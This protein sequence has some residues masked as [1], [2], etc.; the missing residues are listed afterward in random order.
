MPTQ[1]IGSVSVS[2]SK[3]KDHHW[4]AVASG[5]PHGC[6]DLGACLSIQ[7]SLDFV[8]CLS[9]L[10]LTSL[11]VRILREKPHQKPCFNCSV[12]LH[13]ASQLIT[14]FSNSLPLVNPHWLSP[15]NPILLLHAQESSFQEYLF[16]TLPR[17]QMRMTRPISPHPPSHPFED[18]CDI[19]P[20]P[21]TRSFPQSPQPFKDNKGPTCNHVGQSLQ[22]TRK[23]FCLHRKAGNRSTSLKLN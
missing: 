3:P 18:E 12:L 14:L 4:H 23:I 2:V 8:T 7:F 22:H 13:R 15:K 21:L 10:C 20:L 19:F 5:P 6:S 11:V 16:Y 1:S 17:T 9:S